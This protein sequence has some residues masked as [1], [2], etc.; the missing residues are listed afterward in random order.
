MTSEEIRE[1]LEATAPAAGRGGLLR[2]QRVADDGDVRLHL[3][4]LMRALEELDQD[5]TVLEIREAL[6]Q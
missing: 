1:A 3:H 2:G 5:V 6:E 4:G